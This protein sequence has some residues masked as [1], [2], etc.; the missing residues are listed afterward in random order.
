MMEDFHDSARRAS[1][2]LAAT[3]LVEA[4]ARATGGGGAVPPSSA[5]P[6]EATVVGRPIGLGY[7]IGRDWR[8]CPVRLG[9]STGSGR[10]GGASRRARLLHRQRPEGG[11]PVGLRCSL[12][13]IAPRA[14]G[15]RTRSPSKRTPHVPDPPHEGC[16]EGGGGD[17]KEG[18]PGPATTDEARSYLDLFLDTCRAHYFVYCNYFMYF[19]I[20]F[21]VISHL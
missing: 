5:T 8:G 2:V 4:E 13:D 12:S 11:C 6:Q 10:R 16:T 1:K 21:P 19:H 3:V 7:S 20:Q 17:E 15:R 14:G 18:A 9:Y